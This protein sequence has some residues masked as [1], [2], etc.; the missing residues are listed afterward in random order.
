[1]RE[2]LL[3]LRE[4]A[5]A[6]AK[7]ALD[8]VGRLAPEAAVARGLALEVAAQPVHQ[9]QRAHAVDHHPDGDRDGRADGRAQLAG[10][11]QVAHDGADRRAHQREDDRQ[12]RAIQQPA[13]VALLSGSRRAQADVAADCCV[14]R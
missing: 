1:M 13:H 8:A 3:L 7:R 2:P 6:L 10:V 9:V 11:D 14:R 12:Q 5:I 4:R